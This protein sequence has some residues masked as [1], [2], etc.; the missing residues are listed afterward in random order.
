MPG[1]VMTPLAPAETDK[2][3]PVASTPTVLFIVTVLVTA[4]AAS[5]A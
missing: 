4:L 5:V 2:E 1:T 3:F